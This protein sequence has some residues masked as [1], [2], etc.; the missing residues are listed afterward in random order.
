MCAED[1]FYSASSAKFAVVLF[2][3]GRWMM[4]CFRAELELHLGRLSRGNP[5]ALPRGQNLSLCATGGER[6]I[7][8]S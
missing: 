2:S 8:A 6:I 7:R 1:G 4:G 5:R 3:R